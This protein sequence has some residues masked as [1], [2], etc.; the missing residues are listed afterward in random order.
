LVDTWEKLTEDSVREE[1][2]PAEEQKQGAAAQREESW[3]PEQVAVR[4]ARLP[5]P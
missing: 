2:E 1:Q 5:A 3:E 4:L